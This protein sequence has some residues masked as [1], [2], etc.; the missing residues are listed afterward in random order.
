MRAAHAATG[1]GFH[2]IIST[3][4]LYPHTGVRRTSVG[5]SWAYMYIRT[6]VSLSVCLYVSISSSPRHFLA[7][8]H[9]DRNFAQRL[10]LQAKGPDPSSGSIIC[11]PFR[12]S[13]HTWSFCDF[14]IG[15]NFQFGDSES[16]CIY[17]HTGVQRTPVGSSKAYMSVCMSISLSGRPRRFL[18]I[19]STTRNCAKYIRKQATGSNPL[20][21]SI[22]CLS[23]CLSG[24]LWVFWDFLFVLISSVGFQRH[25]AFISPY[26]RPYL[27]LYVQSS[28]SPFGDYLHISQFHTS[29]T[30]AGHG[31]KYP[32]WHYNRSVHNSICLVVRGTF[33]ILYLY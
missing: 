14:C 15:T 7:I 13:S 25:D 20:S 30:A 27:Y 21:G 32:E 1:H 8:I 16:R 3:V 24:H 22:I 4:L 2:S 28:A 31:V 17:P 29:H 9:A 19:I 33:A 10:W 23:V 12:L 5:S 26:V 6:S 18:E 11:P